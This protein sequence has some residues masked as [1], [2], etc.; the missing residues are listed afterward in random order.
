MKGFE[1]VIT[2]TSEME[3]S[4]DNQQVVYVGGTVATQ[5]MIPTEVPMES[6]YMIM[7]SVILQERRKEGRIR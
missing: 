6:K 4:M 7:I 2:V 3:C 1:P 5:P